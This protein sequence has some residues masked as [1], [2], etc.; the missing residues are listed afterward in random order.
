MILYVIPFIVITGIC[1]SKDHT[2]G[3]SVRSTSVTVMKPELL[4]MFIKVGVSICISFQYC[5]GRIDC[6]SSRID[7]IASLSCIFALAL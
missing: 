4:D 6:L 3:P 2:L 1:L 7:T 5:Y